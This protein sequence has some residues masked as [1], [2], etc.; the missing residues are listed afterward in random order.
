LKYFCN[1]EI[2][3]KDV[4]DTNG[5]PTSA[6]IAEA[7]DRC[8]DDLFVPYTEGERYLK[9]EQDSL[10]QLFGNVVSEFLNITQQQKAIAARNQSVLTRRLNQISSNSSGVISPSVASPLTSDSI[11]HDMQGRDKENSHLVIVDES[12]FCLLTT[13][14]ILN[15]LGIHTEA[16][17]RSVELEDSPESLDSLKKLFGI[18]IDYMGQKY[19]D[20]AI[21]EVLES[22]S[23]KKD[24]PEMFSLS[25]V[26]SAI[27]IMQLMQKHFESAILPLVTGTPST[28]RD[29]LVLKNKFMASLEQKINR[30]LQKTVEGVVYWLGEILGRQK[31]ND[32]KPKDEEVAMM[33]MGTQPCMQSIEFITKVFRSAAQALQGK[34]F[35]AFLKHIGSGFHSDVA[36]YQELIKMFNIPSLDER[37][38]MLR[39]LGNIF[40]VKPEILKSI[41]SEGYLAR[42][43]PSL[44]YPYLEKRTD[45]KLAKLDRLLGISIGDN[46]EHTDE[47]HSRK[48]GT[49]EKTQR[50]SL[51]VNDNE[52]LKDIMKNYT[53]NRD[54]FSA[55]NLSHF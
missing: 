7:L 22:L 54:F 49:K 52:V 5:L 45:F 50:R 17:V 6:S 16:I 44:L 15:I 53:S 29:L 19:L 51:F 9:K 32:F 42:L 48:N 11:H 39:Q 27:D 25:V 28:H 43:D 8:M 12:G 33:S 41:L 20:I 31:K 4:A 34:N 1:R 37:F 21:D 24:Q 36:K 3:L 38:E 55:F 30:L 10:R 23:N 40:V 26:K 47:D 18:L 13:E 35:E 2:P 46:V 14:A